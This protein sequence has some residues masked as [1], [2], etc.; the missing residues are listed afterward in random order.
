MFI[1]FNLK[2]N[3][4]CNSCNLIV[5]FSNFIVK[6]NINHIKILFL[7]A[8][9]ISKVLKWSTICE[10]INHQL[11]FIYFL[12]LVFTT[13]IGLRGL[14]GVCSRRYQLYFI[15]TVAPNH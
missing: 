7:L 4:N 15:L 12:F 5:S 10:M 6:T 2:K 1:S 8:M 14:V 13:H 3:K 9:F 11:N